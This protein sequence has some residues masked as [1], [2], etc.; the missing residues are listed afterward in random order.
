MVDLP[1]GQPKQNWLR[2]EVHLGLTLHGHGFGRAIEKTCFDLLR[3]EHSDGYFQNEK[4][5]DQRSEDS[6]DNFESSA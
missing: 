4:Q 5:H 3:D 6:K 2:T 1:S